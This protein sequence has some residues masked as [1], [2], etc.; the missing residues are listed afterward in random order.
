MYSPE[1]KL[2]LV[3]SLVLLGCGPASVDGKDGNGDGADAS[4]P[5]FGEPEACTN[6]DLLFVIDDSGSMS[7]EQANLTTNFSKF[8]DIIKNYRNV[9]DKPVDFRIGVTTTGRDM[10]FVLDPN[11]PFPIPGIPPFPKQTFNESG[12]NGIL[13]QPSGGGPRWLTGDDA[14]LS[15]KFSDLASVGTTGPSTEMPLLMTRWAL[16]APENN[17]FLR[18]DALLGIIYLTD[19]DDCSRV[20]DDWEEG[21]S[22]GVCGSRPDEIIDV[23][24]F[25]VDF[26]NIKGGSG[27]WAAAIVAAQS[28]CMSTLGDAT[29]ATRLKQFAA[30]AGDDSVAWSSICSGDLTGALQAA[31]DKFDASCAAFP[32]ID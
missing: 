15:S 16:Q 29:E 10:S 25:I 11:P 7:E 18:E 1:V 32:D 19:E 9:D 6:I 24:D 5:N 17:G 26:D 30:A 23:Q 4:P 14:S 8:A 31:L 28:D 22:H 27:R 21:G 2:I 13:K 3:M 12:D 20:Q